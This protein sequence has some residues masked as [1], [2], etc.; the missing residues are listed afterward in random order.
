MLASKLI[1]STEPI[2]FLWTQDN[3]ITH[4]EIENELQ[5]LRKWSKQMTIMQLA[6]W[7]IG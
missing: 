4:L 1:V 3:W 6:Y 2:I 7:N 5:P